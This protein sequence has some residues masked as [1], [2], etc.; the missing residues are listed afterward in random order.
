MLDWRLWEGSTEAGEG[1]G[2]LEIGVRLLSSPAGGA[3]LAA[4][5]KLLYWAAVR[6]QPQRTSL[7]VP[8]RDEEANIVLWV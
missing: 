7:R 3:L 4:G 5:T 8:A 6:Q 1:K 2:S